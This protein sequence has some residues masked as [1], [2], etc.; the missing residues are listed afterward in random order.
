MDMS[1]V[2]QS[3]TYTWSDLLATATT[4]G[5]VVGVVRDFIATWTPMEVAALPAPCKPP[6]KFT[7]PEDVVLYAFALVEWQLKAP[8]EDAGVFRMVSFFS[9]AT[10]QVTH[11]MGEVPQ[12]PASNADQVGA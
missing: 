5:Q 1:V 7:Q 12:A 9:E 11:L 8:R 6:A 10:R 3:A 4:P 2:S